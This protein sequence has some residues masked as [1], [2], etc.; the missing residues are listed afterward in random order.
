MK[1]SSQRKAHSELIGH[2]FGL[3]T[4]TRVMSAQSVEC[5]CVCGQIAEIRATVLK[6]GRRHGCPSCVKLVHGESTRGEITPEMRTWLSMLARCRPSG[7]LHYG[8]SGIRV[9]ERWQDSFQAFLAD[10]GRRPSE[11]H[12]IDRIDVRGD[13]EPGN[14]RWST[15]KEQARN[16]RN[17][18]LL[19]I[20][21]ETLCIAEWAERERMPYTTIYSRLKKGWSHRESVYGKRLRCQNGS[22]L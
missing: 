4:V 20:D 2:R 19:T 12:S 6:A 11:R 3:R 17:N 13:Y 8:R 14:V 21:G 10:V 22:Q 15:A 16:R 7:R 5:R 1:R 18:R 9:C